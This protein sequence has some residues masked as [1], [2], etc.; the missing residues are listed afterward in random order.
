MRKTCSFFTNCQCLFDATNKRVKN[1]KN[2]TKMP[3]NFN[4]IQK[5]HCIMSANFSP[6]Y[7]LTKYMFKIRL[8]QHLQFNFVSDVSEQ[9]VGPAFA[10]MGEMK[11]N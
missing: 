4:A 9:S 10:E 2:L 11:K 6:I 5:T 3:C 1:D 8:A 7:S